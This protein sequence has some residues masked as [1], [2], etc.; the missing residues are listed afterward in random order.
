[1]T[2]FLILGQVA[3]WDTAERDDNS[4][5][6]R[7]KGPN[8]D[9]LDWVCSGKVA[10]PGTMLVV[11]SIVA[12]A[13]HSASSSAVVVTASA[14]WVSA[15]EAAAVASGIEGAAFALAYTAGSSV[16]A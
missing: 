2:D 9:L 14:R 5:N 8:L 3:C 4:C 12:V 1:M 7:S 13:A 10:L 16:V 15:F 11:G 6:T